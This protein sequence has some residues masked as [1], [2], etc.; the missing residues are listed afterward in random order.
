MMIPAAYTTP[1]TSGTAA[2]RV[3]PKC[4]SASFSGR[5]G[6]GDVF[7]MNLVSRLSQEVRTATTTADIR[8][9]HQVV[10]ADAYT[11]DPGAI[12]GR[13]LFYTEE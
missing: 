12:A 9:L 13:I 6:G 8:Q 7:F 2:S 1:A 4:D 11:P 3:P 10:S 5:S